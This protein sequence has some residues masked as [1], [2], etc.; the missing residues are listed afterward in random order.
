MAAREGALARVVL[1][2]VPARGGPGE[3]VEAMLAEDGAQIAATRIG[4]RIA[5]ANAFMEGRG[6][7]EIARSGKAAEEVRA[8]AEEVGALL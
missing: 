7:T 2:R 4:N 6:V 1:N 3:A 8:L 5:F